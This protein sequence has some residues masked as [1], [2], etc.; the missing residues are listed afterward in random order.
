MIKNILFGVDG[1][2]CGETARAYAFDLARRLD[3]RL[4][5]VHVVDSRMLEF[6]L[7]GPQPGVI[8]WNPG[9]GDERAFLEAF[10]GQLRAK[11]EG[12]MRFLRQF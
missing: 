6:P 9:A 5:A 10:Y 4:E 1:S 12:D 7:V 3:A 2:P 11:L 8:G